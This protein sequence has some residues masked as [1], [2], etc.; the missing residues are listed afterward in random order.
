MGSSEQ[1]PAEGPVGPPRGGP[2][3]QKKRVLPSLSAPT[4]CSPHS[5]TLVIVFLG[6]PGYQVTLEPFLSNSL[7]TSKWKGCKV[8]RNKSGRIPHASQ[9][10]SCAGCA[11]MPSG[12]C[13]CY[14]P[15]FKEGRWVGV[16]SLD[17]GMI[18]T[19]SRAVGCWKARV[20]ARFFKLR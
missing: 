20:K 11:G 16:R 8:E 14:L 5:F 10:L 17:A 12:C 3:V 18:S 13:F 9:L 4:I 19:D 1:T 7:L 15:R 2:E 6:I